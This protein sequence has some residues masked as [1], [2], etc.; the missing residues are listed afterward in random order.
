MSEEFPKIIML[1]YSGRQA[2]VLHRLHGREARMAERAVGRNAGGT[3]LTY[4]M[5]ALVT[6]LDGQPVVVEDFDALDLEDITAIS[7]ALG[8]TGQ[9]EKKS[10][11]EPVSQP[12]S[13]GGLP[14]RN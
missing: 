6:L 9:A 3:A 11:T 12:L 8:V 1:P 14:P 13:N 2:T 5:M 10:P 7:D 4:A